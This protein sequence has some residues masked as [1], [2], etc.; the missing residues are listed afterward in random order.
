MEQV[1]VKVEQAVVKVEQAAVEQ[2]VVMR[3]LW[4]RQ[5]NKQAAS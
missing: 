5:V 3:C 2:A 1:V 4:A